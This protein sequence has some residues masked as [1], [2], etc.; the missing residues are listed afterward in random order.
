MKKKIAMYVLFAMAVAA[1]GVIS[2]QA[3]EPKG[4]EYR[5]DIIDTH[6]LDAHKANLPVFVPTHTKDCVLMP[7]C[8]A[9]GMNLYQANGTILKFDG[10]SNKKIIDFLNKKNSKLQVVVSAAHNPD[11]TYKLI[12]IKNQ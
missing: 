4:V 7:D 12:Y 3:A 8:Q 2:S 9:S 6:C 11:G 5:G 1:V 10:E